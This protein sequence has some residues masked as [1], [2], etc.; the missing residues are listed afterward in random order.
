MMTRSNPEMLLQIP[1][2]RAVKRVCRDGTGI[3]IRLV[4]IISVMLG[5]IAETAE[6]FAQVCADF[7]AMYD[8]VLTM[9][10][11]TAAPE[12]CSCPL[13]CD[14]VLIGS[15]FTLTIVASRD[16]RTSTARIAARS[17]G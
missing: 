6:Y 16:T 3:S 14:Q 5:K 9:V 12:T 15:I 17:F 11:A 4:K 10:G 2:D 1:S 8:T 13:R 7:R